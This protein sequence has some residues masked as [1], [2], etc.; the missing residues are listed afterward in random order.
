MFILAVAVMILWFP[1]VLLLFAVMPPRRAVIVASLT[2]WLFLPTLS[3]NLPGIPDYTKTSATTMALVM[4]A[5]L[6][7][8]GRLLAMRPRWFDIPIIAWCISPFITSITNDLGAYDGLS[9]SIYQ[10]FRWGFP[11]F[12]GRAYFSDLEGL[13]DLSVGMVVVS[14]IYVP[15]CLW[16]IRMSPQIAIQ[17]YEVN[18]RGWEGTRYGGYRPRV[19]L[20]T[21]LELGMWM[22]AGSLAGF[23]LWASGGLRRLWEYPFGLLLGILLVTTVLC[24]STGA[25]L[26]L[27]VGLGIFWSI[28]KWKWTWPVW[29]LLA[30]PPVYECTRTT[31]LWSGR[32]AVDLAGSLINAERAESLEFRL[33]NEDMLIDKALQR[34]VF[35]WGAWGR[36]RVYDENGKD[37]CI[38]DGYWIIILGVQ[39]VVGL[40][41]MTTTLLL[42]LYLTIVRIPP[43]SW[44]E[45]RYGPAAVLAILLGLYTIDN[46]SNAMLN[47][48]YALV[49]GGLTALDPGRITG[50]SG[51]EEEEEG[52]RATGQE[53]DPEAEEAVLGADALALE[54]AEFVD[55]R[56]RQAEGQRARACHLASA[57]RLD[58]AIDLFGRTIRTQDELVARHPAIGL[59]RRSLAL[60]C[61]DFGQVLGTLGRPREM[62]RLWRRALD[63]LAGLVEEFPE[64]S[65]VQKEWLDHLNN[66]A[67]L[68]ATE[69]DPAVFDPALAA[70]WAAT[71]VERAP[72]CLIYWN[73]LGVAHYRAGHW[74]EAI[75]ALD[76]SAE[77]G[78]GGTSFDHFYLALAHA[79]SGDR[80][81]ARLWYDRGVAWIEIHRSR[82]GPLL[83]L[84]DEAAAALADSKPQAAVGQLTGPPAS[85]RQEPRS[86]SANG[87]R[88]T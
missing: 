10:I 86:A 70:S 19:F 77:L 85:P 7:D 71:A 32:E 15:L 36:S 64:R 59:Y 12:I 40:V 18:T 3:F 46:L 22:T 33:F 38:T 61:I 68:L 27:V 43:R 57:G 72:D 30:L 45:P 2:A 69:S 62:E 55:D 24:K 21:G 51:E 47:P 42:P 5:A 31:K 74:R 79:R 88:S 20:E 73:T 13:R 14:L 26:L 25:L 28:K 11:Y 65:G 37:I 78:S 82:R 83:S 75:E 87:T 44:I 6:F 58:A 66:L 84:R 50:R 52:D 35:G 67:W 81:R 41:L 48:I 60:S 34:P 1:I 53:P 29:V 9:S 23:W 39:G 54:E 4:G 76:R 56:H 8:P 49:V 63:L 16:E 17:V 80:A